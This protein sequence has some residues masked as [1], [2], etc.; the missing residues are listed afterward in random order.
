MVNGNTSRRHEF[1]SGVRAFRQFGDV[2]C[3]ILAA[4]TTPAECRCISPS[5]PLYTS[6]LYSITVLVEAE[7]KKKK[8]RSKMIPAK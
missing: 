1:K 6:L 7:R 8:Y 5:V 3:V 4:S 2:L